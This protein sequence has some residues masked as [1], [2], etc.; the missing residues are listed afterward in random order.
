LH[1]LMSTSRR[2]F[3]D[4]VAQRVVVLDGAMGTAL[5]ERGDLDLQKDWLGHENMSEVLNLTRTDVIKDI[6]RGFLAVGCDA[7]ETNSFGGNRIVMAEAGMPER[8]YEVSRIS[9]VIAREACDEFETPDRPRY[10]IGAMGP[11]TKLVSFGAT[12]WDEME[13]SYFE[14]ARGLIDGG[15][16]VLVIETVQDLLQVKVALAA[17]RR[18]F[19]ETRSK[20]PIMVQASFDLNNG[21]N[22]LTGPD[23]ETFVATFLPF[24][25]I[26]VLGVNCAYGPQEL[27]EAI[28]AISRLWPRHVSILPNAGLPVMIDGRSCFPLGANDFAAGMMRFVEGCGVNIVGGCCGTTVDHLKTLI[29]RLGDRGPLGERELLASATK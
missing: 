28:H 12:T 26:D 1:D 20:L 4:L 13:Q 18:A 23:P 15:A 3:L 17:I 27:S 21:A 6:H 16:D 14:N 2:P 29:D 9:A 7:V 24:E 25:E 19:Y 11:G 5:Q 10:V 8:A 22:M